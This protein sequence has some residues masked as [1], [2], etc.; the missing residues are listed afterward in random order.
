MVGTSGHRVVQQIEGC[1]L[2]RT[3]AIKAE[4]QALERAAQPRIRCGLDYRTTI[5]VGVDVPVKNGKENEV[6]TRL[7]D[8]DCHDR[9]AQDR[10]EGDVVFRLSESPR[11]DHHPISVSRSCDGISGIQLDGAAQVNPSGWVR[12][13]QNSTGFRNNPARTGFVNRE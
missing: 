2:V 7:V 12:Y 11:P 6:G 3:A 9:P 13:S 5:A 1:A 4:W 8:L 10:A